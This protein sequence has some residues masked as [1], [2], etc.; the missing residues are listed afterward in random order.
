MASKVSIGLGLDSFGR[1]I[2]VNWTLVR[3]ANVHI[4]LVVR[5]QTHQHEVV[6]GGGRIGHAPWL[7]RRFLTAYEQSMD[8]EKISLVA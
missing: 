3:V 1:A 8:M 7:A 4:I 6:V 5:R 2:E